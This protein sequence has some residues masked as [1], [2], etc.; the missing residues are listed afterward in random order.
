MRPPPTAAPATARPF[1]TLPHQPLDTFLLLHIQ[2]QCHDLLSRLLISLQ[3]FKVHQTPAVKHRH[4]TDPGSRH[5]AQQA[6]QYCISYIALQHADCTMAAS[7]DL[8]SD[9]LVLSAPTACLSNSVLALWQEPDGWHALLPVQGWE[10]GDLSVDRWEGETSAFFKAGSCMPRSNVSAG[11]KALAAKLW[12]VE[13]AVMNS[14]LGLCAFCAAGLG[15]C[16]YFGKYADRDTGRASAPKLEVTA[17][18]VTPTPAVAP[19][20]SVMTAPGL[21]ELAPWEGDAAD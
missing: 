10:G 15:S 11:C 5:F 8:L 1:P 14:A 18:A 21:P 12:A 3:I 7:T 2:P 4:T 6:S 16:L 19:A 13:L 17:P 9:C 20:P